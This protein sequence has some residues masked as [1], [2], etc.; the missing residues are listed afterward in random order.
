VNDRHYE[1]ITLFVHLTTQSDGS[2]THR[3]FFVPSEI[4]KLSLG[5]RLR[6]RCSFY[7]ISIYLSISLPRSAP[8]LKYSHTTQEGDDRNAV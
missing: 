3:Q 6:V 2:V 4:R 1:L 5:L 8:F 7:P